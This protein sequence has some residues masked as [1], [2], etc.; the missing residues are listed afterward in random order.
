M[1]LEAGLKY[2]SSKHV[3]SLIY[4]PSPDVTCPNLPLRTVFSITSAYSHPTTQ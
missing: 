4:K 2:P 3:L 1:G